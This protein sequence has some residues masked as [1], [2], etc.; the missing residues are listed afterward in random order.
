MQT[1]ACWDL[2]AC[3]QQG[4]AAYSQGLAG[5]LES[6]VYGVIPKISPVITICRWLWQ[7][8]SG[9]YFLDILLI[10]KGD[11]SKLYNYAL[12]TKGEKCSP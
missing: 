10:N 1:V 11:K 5:K 12:P 4:W 2:E 7:K 8:N 9:S 3:L 6:L